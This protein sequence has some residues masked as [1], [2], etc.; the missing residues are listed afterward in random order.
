MDVIEMENEMVKANIP[1]LMELIMMGNGKMVSN[2]GWENKPLMMAI[3]MKGS[4]LM[5]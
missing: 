3:I 2:M 1:L 5:I 4:I